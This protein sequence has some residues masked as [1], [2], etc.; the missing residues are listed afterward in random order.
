M[1]D[2]E[3]N[4]EIEEELPKAK[5]RRRRWSSVT[6]WSIPLIALVVAGYLVYEHLREYGPE[7]TITFQDAS[8]LRPRE[9][10]IV[11]RGVQVGEV[12]EMELSAD[13]EHVRV[14][15]WLRRAPVSVAREGSIFWIVRPEV[16]LGNISGVG[17]VISGPY[18]EVLPGTG[19][20]KSEFMGLDSSPLTLERNPLKIILQTHNAGSLRLGSPVYYRGVEVGA[21]QDMV[22]SR[23]ATSVN[24]HVFIKRQY[25]RLVRSG[26][27][28][29]NVSGVDLNLGLFRGLEIK[30]ESLRS[31]FVGGIAF[32]TPEDSTARP[33][34]NGTIFPL[35]DEPRKEWLLWSPKIPI[36]QEK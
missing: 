27:R 7:I 2:P 15:A 32:A 35:H 25:A 10:Q 26:S 34:R 1:P 31:L 16:R 29:W 33:L 3:G 23:D 36:P 17:T 6:I 11:H 13:L 28:F 4:P 18:I 22:L 24:I 19:P 20:P 5:V 30:L 9:T 21:V 14:K 12:S 8:G